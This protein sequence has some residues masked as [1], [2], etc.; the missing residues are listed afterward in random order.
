MTLIPRVHPRPPSSPPYV[1]VLMNSICRAYL[2][3]SQPH[4]PCGCSRDAPR[5]CVGTALGTSPSPSTEH[6]PAR[7]GQPHGQTSGFWQMGRGTPH[8]PAACTPSGPLLL[9]SRHHR[10]SPIRPCAA[11]LVA[12]SNWCLLLPASSQRDLQG[13]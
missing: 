6:H 8:S 1:P 4:P 5:T 3:R 10:Q 13:Q 2:N 9:P 7:C 11:P 12:Q